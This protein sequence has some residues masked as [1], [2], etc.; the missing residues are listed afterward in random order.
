[1][2][3]YIPSALL[4]ATALFTGCASS[5]TAPTPS[6]PK[7]LQAVEVDAPRYFEQDKCDSVAQ[8][9]VMVIGSHFEPQDIQLALPSDDALGMPLYKKTLTE[10]VVGAGYTL[11]DE[12]P[13]DLDV[14]YTIEPLA[15]G[16]EYPERA[17]LQ[18]TVS[19]DDTT[20]VHTLTISTYNPDSATED[21]YTT[22]SSMIV[23]KPTD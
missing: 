19:L 11:V 2:K 12:S 22:E 1:M 6:T 17:H 9:T 14:S 16:G 13:L 8:A 3:H 4:A 20:V 18:Q 7:A 10:A 21:A 23:S 15:P 5:M